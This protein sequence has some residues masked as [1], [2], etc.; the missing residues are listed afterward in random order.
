MSPDVAVVG[1]GVIG[2]AIARALAR[3]GAGRV[4][5]VDR[6]PAGGEAS[7]AA[8]GVLAVASSRAARGA[9]SALKRASLQRYPDWV[10]E[11][12]EESGI[13]V[14][15]AS[16]GVLDLAF[17]SREAE[18]LERFVRR[19]AERGFR[20]ERLDGDAVRTAYPD[21][22]P[23]VRRA[24]FFA[25]DATVHPARLI[26]A[27]VAAGTAHGVCWQHGA[28]LRRVH[29]RRGRVLALEVGDTRLTPGHVILAA[30]AWSRAVGRLLPAAIPVRADRG[31]MLAVRPASP[32]PAPLFWEKAC[33][34]PRADGEVLIGST[35]DRRAAEKAV[36]AGHAA[37]L[38]EQAVR[39]VPALAEAPVTR[40]WSGLRP[41]ARTARPIIGPLRGYA[42][43]TVATGHHR[44][45]I[46]LAPAT[47]DLVAELLLQGR[48]S[49]D[50]QPFCHR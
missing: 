11:L 17:T 20:V 4:V 31:E 29:A 43:V 34:V 49:I 47:A 19:Q 21:V 28:A 45:G 22:N 50:L 13:D 2:C 48:T 10:A 15:Y 14:E 37:R 25:D 39:M 24:A 46:L 42:N 12:S 3:G 18:R 9:L 5:V 27:L 23:A 26:E 7:S 44:N 16:T 35:S 6:G 30:G 36:T 1:A 41:H 40:I 33:L 32:L 38:L 8:A